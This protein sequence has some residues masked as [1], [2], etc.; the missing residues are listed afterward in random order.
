LDSHHRPCIR[1]AI[2]NPDWELTKLNW[3]CQKCSSVTNLDFT[4][5]DLSFLDDDTDDIDQLAILAPHH[6]ISK[7]GKGSTF[8]FININEVTGPFTEFIIS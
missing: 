8:A 6:I 7:A 3:I 5:P 4:L 2:Q 1:P